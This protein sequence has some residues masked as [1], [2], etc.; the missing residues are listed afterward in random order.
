MLYRIVRAGRCGRLRRRGLSPCDGR[1]TSRS[2]RP[3]GSGGSRRT[4]GPGVPPATPWPT[5]QPVLSSPASHFGHC[6]LRRSPRPD[7]AYAARSCSTQMSPDRSS[8]DPGPPRWHSD[9]PQ[10]RGRVERA[11]RRRDTGLRGRRR[12]PLHVPRIRTPHRRQQPARVSTQRQLIAGD[13][14]T[15]SQTRR[16]T[17]R[18][19]PSSSGLALRINRAPASSTAR[20]WSL[21]TQLGNSD[22]ST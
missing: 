2:P 12:N 7:P 17:C 1:A 19:P 11:G 20:S 6:R 8:V 21:P 3:T 10:R 22:S 16:G 14:W 4:R 9:P 13:R 5:S 15:R 18:F